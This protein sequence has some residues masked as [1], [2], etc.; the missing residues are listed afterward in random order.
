MREIKFRGKTI[1]GGRWTYGYLTKRGYNDVVIGY[2]H[3][4][5][6]IDPATV[7]Q[8]TGLRDS[9]RSKEYPKGQEIYE[10]DIVRAT[11]GECR[12]GMWEYD[13]TEVVSDIR[14]IPI[15]VSEAE[16]INVIGNIYDNP[17]LEGK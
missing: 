2:E 3:D 4:I 14:Y 1:L 12:N 8:Y 15:E 5:N 16:N 13:Y 10:G 7:G 17:E 11:G 9:V 6:Y